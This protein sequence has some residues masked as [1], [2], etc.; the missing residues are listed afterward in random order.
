MRQHVPKKHIR[1][2]SI[3]PTS[4]IKM[5]GGGNVLQGHCIRGRVILH[6]AF[7]SLHS[8]RRTWYLYHNTTTGI[9]NYWVKKH[10]G[11]DAAG[12]KD[13]PMFGGNWAFSIQSGG[14]GNFLGTIATLG[15][16]FGMTK[17]SSGVV[18]DRGRKARS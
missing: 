18:F 3:L 12:K 11:N 16:N 6:N 2:K 13:R 5:D 17:S 8:Q 9:I 15:I 4:T 7:I 14:S 10:L 1:K